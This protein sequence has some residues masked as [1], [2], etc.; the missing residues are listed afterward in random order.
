MN[1]PPDILVLEGFPDSR[2]VK[3]AR[4]VK[5]LRQIDVAVQAGVPVGMVSFIERGW[6]IPSKTRAKILAIVGLADE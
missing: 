2:R 6:R 5:G 3:I 1:N 4:C